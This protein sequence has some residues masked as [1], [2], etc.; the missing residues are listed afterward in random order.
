MTGAGRLIAVV[1]PSGAGKDTLLAGAMAARPGWELVRRVITRPAG[2]GEDH[3]PVGMAEFEARRALGQFALHWQAH[4]LYY[5]IPRPVLARVRGGATVLF[6]GS[7]AALPQARSVWP[8][9][10][11]VMVTAPIPVLAARLSARGRESAEAIAA[12]L[13]RS[14]L[15][16]PEGARVVQNDASVD[17]GV[18]RLLAVLSPSEECA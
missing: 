18:A 9:L 6:N 17:E 15:P 7:R 4:G 14:L 12:R 3:E 8:R 11:V 16:P 13:R 1:G 10:E 2:V 5:G